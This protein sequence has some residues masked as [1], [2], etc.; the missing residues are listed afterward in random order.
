MRIKLKAAF[1]SSGFWNGDSF[2]RNNMLYEQ[3]SC[4]YLSLFY[5][6]RTL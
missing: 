5:S 4:W 1:F 3:K 6:K 2:K